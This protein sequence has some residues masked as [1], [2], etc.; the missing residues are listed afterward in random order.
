VQ[1]NGKT[2]LIYGAG[3]GIAHAVARAYAKAG[4]RLFLSTRTLAKAEP[5]AAEL[6]AEL[7][8][9]DATDPAAVDA[10]V[11]A[12][13]RRAGRIDISFNLIGVGDVQ[14]PLM[15]ISPDDFVRPIATAMRA[16]F[17]TGRA[18]ARHMI[19]QKSGVILAF[20]G[21]GKQTLA[22]LVGF[23]IAL[24]AIEA[25]RRQWAIE[26]GPH[27]IRVLTLKSGGVPETLAPEFADRD[28]IRRSIE[29]S[30]PMRRAA[31][32]DDVGAVAV[33]AA[34][35]AARSLTDTWLNIGFGAMPD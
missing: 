25:L 34:S 11:D 12:V 14:K 7:E 6:G 35:D 31:D 13:A 28:A 5:L 32:P 27:G 21:G 1:L 20:G 22:G 17:I 30:S 19:E 4:A 9:V 2:A 15:E 26:L 16:Q 23:K 10:Y 3:G 29:Q 33:F 18:A 8:Q 24:D